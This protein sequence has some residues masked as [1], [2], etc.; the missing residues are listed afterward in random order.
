MSKRLLAAFFAFGLANYCGG[1][2]APAALADDQV[3]IDQHVKDSIVYV[4]IA[5]TGYVQ[6]PGNQTDDGKSMWS[7]STEVDYTCTGF[8]VDP[9]GFIA[10]AG[11]CVNVDTEVKED[12]RAQMISNLVD[13]GKLDKAKAD[14]LT[15]T[16]NNEEWPVEG[17]DNDSPII[18][19]VQVI[20]PELQNRVI[21]QFTTVQVVDAQSFDDGDNA[22]LKIS[23]MPP[24]K[25]LVIANKAPDPG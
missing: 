8:I 13:D 12:I 24:L 10:T 1:V 3:A 17:K 6:I 23:G 11:H 4:S 18:R 16:A 19:S 20:Q 21:T 9:S 22:L 7:D 2:S 5:D 25:P 15:D 14:D